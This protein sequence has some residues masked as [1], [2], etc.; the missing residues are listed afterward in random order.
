MNA[1]PC[2]LD[3]ESWIL[4]PEGDQMTL[5]KSTVVMDGDRIVRFANE[6]ETIDGEVRNILNPKP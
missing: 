3:P 1:E 5:N 6:L 4:N 2:I